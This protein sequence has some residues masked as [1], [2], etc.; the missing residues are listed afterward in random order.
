MSDMN[1][2]KTIFHRLVELGQKL[3]DITPRKFRL[4]VNHY[5]NIYFISIRKFITYGFKDLPA[6]VSIET[7]SICTRSCYYCPRITDKD[8]ILD[9]NIFYSIIDQ[10]KGFGFRGYISLNNYN[11]PLTDSRI[12]KFIKYMREQLKDSDII[13]NTNGDLLTDHDIKE[14]IGSGITKIVLTIHEPSS[15]EFA[16]RMYGFQEKYNV[17]RLKDFRDDHRKILLWNRGG[18]TDVGNIKVFSSCYLVEAMTISAGGKVL[19]CCN[20]PNEKYSFGN[21]KTQSLV[22][23]WSN[24]RYRN[25]RHNIKTGR[26]KLPICQKCG[27]QF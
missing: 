24:P 26:S 4:Y 20:D 15:K 8:E 13:L 14:L 7:N 25:Y 27:T 18:S 9:D 23:I 21:V 6:R 5:S 10:L 16:E 1:R 19:L 11:E 3:F 22:D 12:F 17:I 2:R